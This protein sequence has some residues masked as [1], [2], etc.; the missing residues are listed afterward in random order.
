MLGFLQASGCSPNVPLLVLHNRDH[1][2]VL[3]RSGLG[4]LELTD[5]SSNLGII[6]D[7]LVKRL[8]ILGQSL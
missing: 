2:M 5:K 7:L 1:G 6:L 8:D 3:F 4:G